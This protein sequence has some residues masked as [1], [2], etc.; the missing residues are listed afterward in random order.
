MPTSHRTNVHH[1]L[2]LPQVLDELQFLLEPPP[3]VLLYHLDLEAALEL[4]EEERMRLWQTLAQ[5][6]EPATPTTGEGHLE[7]IEELPADNE[8][9]AEPIG[10]KEPK[11]QPQAPREDK[12]WRTTG[13]ITCGDFLHITLEGRMEL[14]LLLEGT[15]G[16]NLLETRRFSAGP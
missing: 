7:K 9:P 6:D 1:P 11:Q 5:E 14:T 12:T 10:G 13:T 8:A 4:N 2:Q 15:R 3:A 16:Y